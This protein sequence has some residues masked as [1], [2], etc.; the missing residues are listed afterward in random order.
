M[1]I[2]V[3]KNKS[4]LNGDFRWTVRLEWEWNI[5]VLWQCMMA[6]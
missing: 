2:L 6:W 1:N 3:Y 5:C 4:G